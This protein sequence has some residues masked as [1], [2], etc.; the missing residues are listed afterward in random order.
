MDSID[1]VPRR[2][3]VAFRS[4]LPFIFVR[5]NRSREVNE[6]CE[7]T[8]VRFYSNNWRTKFVEILH[9]EGLSL[10]LFPLNRAIFSNK[11]GEKYTR[12]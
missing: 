10:L 3:G 11:L 8:F 1:P 9:F 12:I 4:H 7:S 2:N 6:P 5:T